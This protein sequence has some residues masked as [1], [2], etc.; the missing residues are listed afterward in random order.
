L[1]GVRKPSGI[2]GSLGSAATEAMEPEEI[3]K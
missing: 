2:S 3:G 1:K